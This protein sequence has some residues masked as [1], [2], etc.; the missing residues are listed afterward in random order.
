M[1][2]DMEKVYGKWNIFTNQINDG[3]TGGP[4]ILFNPTGDTM[5]ISQMSEFMAGSMKKD[6]LSLNYGIMSGVDS[7]PRNYSIEFA[8]YYSSNGINKGMQEWGALLLKFY[9]KNL[10]I[11]DHDVTS[12]YLSYWT[13]NGFSLF[14][15]IQ[16]Y[17]KIIIIIVKVLTITG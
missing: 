12:S 3:I 16:K 8:I 9:N 6:G 4:L 5:I 14:S 17:S 10:N 11:K 13:D 7:I 15:L 2:G 1:A